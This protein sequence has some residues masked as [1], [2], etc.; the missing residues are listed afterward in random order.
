MISLAVISLFWAVHFFVFIASASSSSTAPILVVVLA[1]M[2]SGGLGYF[3]DR[4]SAQAS[5]LAQDAVSATDVFQR[6]LEEERTKRDELQKE[7]DQAKTQLAIGLSRAEMHDNAISELKKRIANL[8]SSL[9]GTLRDMNNI[10]R[11]MFST[12]EDEVFKV[13]R[14]RQIMVSTKLAVIQANREVIIAFAS[15]ECADLLKYS[16]ND[17]IG[18][19]LSIIIHDEDWVTFSRALKGAQAAEKN[20]ETADPISLSMEARDGKEIPVI[21]ALGVHKGIITL[22]I[23]PSAS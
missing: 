18:K 10:I 4:R 6:S 16:P 2:G 19:P 22:L 20:E 14:W 17:L 8:E 1:L 5:R 9:H 23:R 3:L 21:M 7:L 15:P 11:E 12:T 13:D